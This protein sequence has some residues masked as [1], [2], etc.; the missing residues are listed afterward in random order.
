MPKEAR[1]RFNTS[2][3]EAVKWL[4]AEG[5]LAHGAGDDDDW[6]DAGGKMARWFLQEEGLGKAKVG[7]FLG[8]HSPLQAR[9]LQS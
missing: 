8:G 1:W 4:V 6:T 2:P 7:E 3:K 5:A 9:A